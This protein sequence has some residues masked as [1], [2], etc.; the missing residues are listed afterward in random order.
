MK[1]FTELLPRS[2]GTR[3]HLA[4]LA[5]L[6]CAMPA[7]M[8]V[9]AD[10]ATALATANSAPALECL[11]DL[12]A[13]DTTLQKDGYW[14]DGAGQGYGIPVYGYGYSYGDRYSTVGR[15]SR[16]RPGYEIRTMMAAAR[17]LGERGQDA[18]CESVLGVARQAYTGYLTE[19]RSGQVPIAD[20]STW[21]RQQIE[22]A[23]PV[24]GSGI[25]YR[26]DQLIGASV[27]NSRD[28]R[29]GS[30]EDLVISPQ[31]GRIAYLVIG[32]GGLFGIDEKYTPV[33]WQDFKSA[34]GTNLLVLTVTK[35]ALEAAPRILKNQAQQPDVFAA[36]SQKI[37]QYWAAYS[38]IAQN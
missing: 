26:S 8:P 34:S 5:V 20:V 7:A 28:E 32:H 16:A 1:M 38:A 14:L 24:A 30:I 17:I 22:S 29:L 13:F 9:W 31:T 35:A 27:V 12:R 3:R 4:L 11:N 2:R 18:S 25:A 15:Y 19:L 37:D 21:R 10:P 33:P 6:A 23:V 36:Q